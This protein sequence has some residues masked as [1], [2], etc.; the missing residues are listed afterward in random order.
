MPCLCYQTINIVYKFKPAKCHEK[1]KIKHKYIY[2]KIFHYRLYHYYYL[3]YFHENLLIIFIVTIYFSE[4]NYY[5]FVF[6][7]ILA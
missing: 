5:L 2:K 4:I 1:N 7:T 3:H 6:W